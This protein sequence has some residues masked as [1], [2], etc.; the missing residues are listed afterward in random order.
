MFQDLEGLPESMRSISEEHD[1]I[2]WANSADRRVTKR[3]RGMQT[4]YI[5]TRG[6]PYTEDHWMR[7]FI[8]NMM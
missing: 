5:Y 3:I 8:K 4:M 1:R 7:D 2:E 6:T